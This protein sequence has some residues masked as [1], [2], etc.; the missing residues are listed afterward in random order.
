MKKNIQIL[1]FGQTSMIAGIMLTNRGYQV[2]I[3]DNK[4]LTQTHFALLRFKTKAIEQE[5]GIKLEEVEIKKGIYADGKIFNES[6][7]KFDNFYS[8]KVTGKIQKRSIGNL[9]TGKRYTPPVDFFDQLIKKCKKLDIKITNDADI[10]L[11]LTTREIINKPSTHF[12]STLPMPKLYKMVHNED[13]EFEFDKVFVVEFIIDECDVHQTIYYP[14]NEPS[15]PAYRISIVGNIMKCE[16]SENSMKYYKEIYLYKFQNLLYNL[17][18]Q[19]ERSFGI[20]ITNHIENYLSAGVEN[21]VKEQKFGKI[22]PIDEDL[23]QKII[24]NLTKKFQIYSLGRFACWRQI[25]LDDVVKDVKRIENLLK[26][27]NLSDYDAL[28]KIT[29][30]MPIN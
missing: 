6:N 15:N 4:P 28:K 12:I 26:I 21:V 2:E 20:S 17:K 9:S 16:I 1:G 14:L 13:V 3:I 30:E 7:I 11:K 8:K 18:Q 25:M 29:A 23:R 19:I 5:T 27:E 10:D 24:Y 22:S